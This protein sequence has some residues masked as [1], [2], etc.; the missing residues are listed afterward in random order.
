MQ[1]TARAEKWL[2]ALMSG[3]S[4]VGGVSTLVGGR[5]YAYAA[6]S[7]VSFPFVVFSHMGDYDVRAVGT[8]RIL[9]SMTYQVKAVGRGSAVGMNAIKTIADRIDTLLQGASGSVTDGVI[10]SC[11]REQQISYVEQAESEVYMHLG[12]IYRIQVSQ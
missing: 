8:A 3:D 5:I 12:G 11:V 6:P 9:A 2:Y 4:G 1:E 7:R 10:L